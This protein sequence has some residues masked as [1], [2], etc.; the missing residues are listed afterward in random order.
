MKIMPKVACEASDVAGSSFNAGWTVGGGVEWLF[1]PQWSAKLEYLYYDLGCLTTNV[2]LAP[3][4]TPAGVALGSVGQQASAHFN[5]NIVRVGVNYRFNFAPPS[6]DP[7]AVEVAP[8]P[9]K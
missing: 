9:R 6:I 8:P 7:C 1:S 5:G 3:V 4:V 2:G